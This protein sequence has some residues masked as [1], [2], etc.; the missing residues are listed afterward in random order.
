[1]VR[2]LFE[3]GFSISS[4]FAPCRAATDVALAVHHL[5]MP[6][7]EILVLTLAVGPA[8]LLALRPSFRLAANHHSIC[9]SM[10]HLEPRC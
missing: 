2:Q 8:A 7:P 1:M 4:R 3:G 6:L 5:R 10:R 9:T